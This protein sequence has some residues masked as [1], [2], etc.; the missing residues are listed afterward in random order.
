M[1]NKNNTDKDFFPFIDHWRWCLYKFASPKRIRNWF[2]KKS[3]TQAETFT[4]SRD[5]SAS[6]SKFFVLPDTLEEL[7]VFLPLMRY[8][9]SQKPDPNELLFLG[10]KKFSPLLK[11]L[12]LNSY[13]QTYDPAQFKYGSLT[14]AVIERKVTDRIWDL[15]V[16]LDPNPNILKLYL[17]AKAGSQ[18]R[19]GFQ[20]EHNYPFL[21]ISFNGSGNKLLIDYRNQLAGQLKIPTESLRPFLAQDAISQ[22]SHNVILLNLEPSITGEVWTPDEIIKL[23]AAIGASYRFLA[24]NPSS[25]KNSLSPTLDKLGIRTAPGGA[26]FQFFIEQL[27]QY[28]GLISLNS[29]HGILATHLSLSPILIFNG[30]SEGNLSSYVS[31]EMRSKISEK[32]VQLNNWLG[33]LPKK[34]A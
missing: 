8:L 27:R 29:P 20:N 28:P 26:S 9:V 10:P 1:Q 17:I 25:T 14:F 21:N 33:T 13:Y 24:I 12:D 16:C 34:E 30:E 19:V 15:V 11:R 32:K 5:L 2:L 18:H 31:R 23:S 4:F 22:I 6:N 7:S 3:G